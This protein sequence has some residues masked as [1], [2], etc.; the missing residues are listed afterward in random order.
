MK[1]ALGDEICTQWWNLS[2]APNFLTTFT[3]LSENKLND[4]KIKWKKD[5][6][7]EKKASCCNG[8]HFRK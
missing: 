3:N 5:K 8:V 2:I 6:L 1:F 4:H 7:V